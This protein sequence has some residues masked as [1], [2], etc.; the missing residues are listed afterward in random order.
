M[1]LSWFSTIMFSCI[2]DADIFA[3]DL[4]ADM[5]IFVKKGENVVFSIR[6]ITKKVE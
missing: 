5:V 6:I 2:S 4:G 1:I 3:N